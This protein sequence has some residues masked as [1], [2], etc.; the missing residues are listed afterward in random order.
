MYGSTGHHETSVKT[1][2][3]IYPLS[4]CASLV[5]SMTPYRI[6][7]ANAGKVNEATKY[8]QSM[9]D[10]LKNIF[11]TEN[12]V[13]IDSPEWGQGSPAGSERS[14]VSDILLCLS[15]TLGAHQGS[16]YDDVCHL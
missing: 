7:G 10:F 8:S 14:E 11:Y 16:D 4:N 13:L 1:N 12:P 3:F 9:K 5:F 15:S 2:I 6:K